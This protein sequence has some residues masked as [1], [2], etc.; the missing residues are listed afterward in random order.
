MKKRLIIII[1]FIGLC[2]SVNAQKKFENKQYGFAIQEPKNW[3][4]ASNEVLKKNLVKF[5]VS[6]ENLAKLIENSKGSIL[7]TSFYKYDPKTTAGLIPTI[8]INVRN[9]PVDDFEYFKSLIIQSSK[10][11]VK[12]F[13]DFEFIE[14]AKE[15]EISG[16]NSVYFIGKFTMKG[17]DG[18]EMKVRSRTYAIPFKKYFF[19]VNFTD[20]QTGE[21]CTLEFDELI[22]T[23]KIGLKL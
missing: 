22:K 21:D 16:I 5:E 1:V 13:E 8:Q 11:F 19:Q 9:K 23:I 4:E 20:G 17:K 2:F 18:Q 3:I 7:L 10:G 15:I 14:E 12:V 6:D